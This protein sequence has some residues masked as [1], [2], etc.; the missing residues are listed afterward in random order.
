MLGVSA[1]RAVERAVLAGSIT[2]LTAAAW[3]ALWL[4]DGAGYGF[5]HHLPGAHAHHAP[6]ALPF[7]FVGGWAVMTIAMMLPTTLPVI[8]TFHAIA[9]GRRDRGLLVGLAIGGY[10][11]AWT[12]FGAAVYVAG[13][14]LHQAMMSVAALEQHS[15]MGTPLL[16]LLAGAFQ[17]SSL[18]Y[19]CL[20]KC[21]SPLSFVVEHWQGRHDAWQAFRLGLDSGIY[22]V[23]CCW[24]LMLLM[25]IVGAGSLGWMLVLAIV[26]GIEKNVRWGR[27]M[28][29][30]VGVALLLWGA[31]LLILPLAG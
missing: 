23:G 7:L 8:F 29:A 9:G 2:L 1:P 28:S 30:P 12:L 21:R 16:L 3:L 24:A 22:C 14:K 11:V 19:R 6:P 13:Q 25:F 15:W 18:K 17:F 20:E 4:A 31:A 10:L 27:R 5:L 26:M